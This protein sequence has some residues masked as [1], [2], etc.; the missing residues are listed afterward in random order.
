MD[1]MSPALIANTVARAQQGAFWSDAFDPWAV[2]DDDAADRTDTLF[3]AVKPPFAIADRIHRFSQRA[4]AAR[5]LSCSLILARC[6]HLTLLGVGIYQTTSAATLE[7]L[8][9]AAAMA[10]MQPFRLTLNRTLRF[11]NERKSDNLPFVLVGDDSIT[12]GL[13]QLR[14]ELADALRQIGFRPRLKAFKPHLTLFYTGHDLGED[15]VAEI[16]WT[17][18]EFAL[19]HSVRGESRH[20]LLG[21]WRL[22]S[23]V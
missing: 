21:V 20:E 5:G 10:T 3:F 9:T 8:R 6:L 19:I 22:G 16:G 17:V 13:H 7:G 1:R 18:R 15:P 12:I 11:G 2:D 14:Q 4:R 23:R